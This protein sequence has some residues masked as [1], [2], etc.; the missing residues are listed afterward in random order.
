[1]DNSILEKKTTVDSESDI[2]DRSELLSKFNTVRSFTEKLCKPLE[3]EDYVIQSMP[4]VS[5]TK[6]HLGHTSWF[7]ETFILEKAI[8]DYKPF[9]PLYNYLFNSYYI[10]VGERWHRPARGLLSRPTVKEI[11]EYRNHIN[12]NIIDLIETSDEKLYNEFAPIFEIGLNHEQQHQELLLTDIKNVLSINP[13]NPVYSERKI[14]PANTTAKLEWVGFDGGVVEIGSNG[15]GFK[16]DN[17]TP[18]HKVFL[19]PFKLTN[20]LITNQEFIDF[21]EDGGYDTAT[22]WLSDGWATVESEAWNENHHKIPVEQNINGLRQMYG[23][24]WEW[25]QSPYTPYPGYKPLPGALG[26]YNGKV[27]ACHP[28]LNGKLLLEIYLI[29]ETLLRTKITILFL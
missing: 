10:Q 24:V 7:F 16:F 21:I 6:W 14:N 3:I 8:T 1:L 29:K 22:L 4:D 25:T 28:K 12:S 20:R 5:P 23:D 17:E 13:L 2:N 11:F 9:H 19:Y 27:V 15:S 18:L 26:E